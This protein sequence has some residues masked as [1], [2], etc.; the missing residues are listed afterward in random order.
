[1]IPFSLNPTSGIAHWDAISEA[2]VAES[3]SICGEL[4]FATCPFHRADANKNP[5]QERTN[6]NASRLPRHIINIIIK[7]SISDIAFLV[8]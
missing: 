4:N 3:V 2:K 7:F 8:L 1:M 5:N 6:H